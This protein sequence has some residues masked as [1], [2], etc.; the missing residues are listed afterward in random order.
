MCVK[1]PLKR[2]I[3]PRSRNFTIEIPVTVLLIPPAKWKDVASLATRV[4]H[5]KVDRIVFFRVDSS[6]PSLGYSN[7]NTLY[8]S[9]QHI[10]LV[11]GG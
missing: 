3:F 4:D 11:H 8:R 10:N 2:Y 9:M 1:G 7:N 5:T 6:V